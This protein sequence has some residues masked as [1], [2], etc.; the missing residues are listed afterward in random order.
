[1]NWDKDYWTHHKDHNITWTADIALLNAWEFEAE[2]LTEGG[3]TFV[4]AISDI[5]DSSI[6]TT[7]IT[8]LSEYL[9]LAEIF[10]ED[11]VNTLAK[12]EP[13]DLALKTSEVPPF[14][15]LYNLS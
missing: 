1:M 3:C 9:D 12:Y 5:V 6:L 10:S 7:P 13:Q 14:G 15:P 4:L 2:C 8:I 11:A